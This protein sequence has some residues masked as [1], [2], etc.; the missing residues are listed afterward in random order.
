[1]PG[2]GLVQEPGFVAVTFGTG[3]IMMAPVSVCHHVSTIGQ[4]PPPMTLLIPDPRFGIDRLAHAAEQP[5]LRQVVLRGNRIPEL[6]Q[7]A[8]R[9]RR[10]VEDSHAVR[11]A[12]LPEAPAV[13]IRGRAFVQHHRRAVRE[14]GPYAT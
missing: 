11:L 8:N 1:M 5:Q 7:R 9:R 12:D 10:R 4:R 13:R 2:S 6:H 14:I 3:E